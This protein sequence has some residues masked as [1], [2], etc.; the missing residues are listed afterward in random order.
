MMLSH[1]LMMSHYVNHKYHVIT[2]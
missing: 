2:L 1:I